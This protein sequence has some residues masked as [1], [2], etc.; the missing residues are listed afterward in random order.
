MPNYLLRIILLIAVLAATLAG[1]DATLPNRD[2]TGE[3]FPTV[4]GESLSEEP[5]ELPSELAG[6]PAILLI[7]YKQEAQFDIDRWL[8][9]ILQAEIGVRVLEV[10][11]IPGLV[12]KMASGYIDGGMRGGIP[13]EDWSIVVTLYGDAAKPVAEF[14]GTTNGQ[15]ARVLVL[16]SDGRVA[17]FDDKGYSPKKA[18][19][20]A[21]FIAAME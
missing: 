2:P 8:M 1:C 20:L 19:A 7:G 3:V 21:G 14:T 18:L 11:T 5:A 15:I 10:P 4:S 6:E 17:W 9:G 12:A 16:D 13:A